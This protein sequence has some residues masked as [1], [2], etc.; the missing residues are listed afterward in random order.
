MNGL[1]LIVWN[2]VKGLLAPMSIQGYPFGLLVILGGIA[3]AIP[4]KKV[5]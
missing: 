1:D 5:R 2:Y 3:A 4:K